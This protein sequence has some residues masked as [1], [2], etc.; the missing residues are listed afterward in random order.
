MS[1]RWKGNSRSVVALTSSRLRKGDERPKGLTL[2]I[3]YL[4]LT[5]T[6]KYKSRVPKMDRRQALLHAHLNVH[7]VIKDKLAVTKLSRSTNNN[8]DSIL[9][10]L[11]VIM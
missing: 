2:S 3:F 4:S 5:E 6:Y 11:T 10:F 8:E 7:K 1:C 9:E